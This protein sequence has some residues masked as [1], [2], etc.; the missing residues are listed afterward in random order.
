MNYNMYYKGEYIGFISDKEVFL[1]SEGVTFVE[2]VE[3]KEPPNMLHVI[4][5]GIEESLE[6]RLTDAYDDIL[7]E[8]KG[9]IY[10]DYGRVYEYKGCTYVLEDYENGWAWSRFDLIKINKNTTTQMIPE[11]QND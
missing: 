6:W 3:E 9:L 7:E 1:E 5:T 11:V 8:G 4:S 2:R 10:F